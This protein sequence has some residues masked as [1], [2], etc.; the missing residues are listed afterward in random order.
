M[1]HQYGYYD[2]W[3]VQS[4]TCRDCGWQGTGEDATFGDIYA[5][6]G[7]VL[8]PRCNAILFVLA[9]PT[10]EESR[11]NWDKLDDAGKRQVIRRETRDQDI[12]RRSLKAPENLPELD[13]E[14][15][16]FGW[17]QQGDDML[18]TYGDQIIWRKPVF[19]E[20]S[21]RFAEVAEILRQKYG[22]RLR[23]LV[24]SEQSKL[25]LYGDWTYTVTKVEQIIQRLRDNEPSAS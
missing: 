5:T 9:W 6:F 10:T 24:P 2:D 17:D 16:I 19:Y 13:G 11:Q 12:A 7:E 23:D 3:K 8:C 15:L 4:Q 14:E 22:D 20:G 21:D 1:G 25:Y 18:I